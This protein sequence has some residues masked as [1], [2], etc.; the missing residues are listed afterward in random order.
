MNLENC[1]LTCQNFLQTL[2]GEFN[3]E[4]EAFIKGQSGKTTEPG[5]CPWVGH[6]NED[7]IKEEVLSLSAVSIGSILFIQLVLYFIPFYL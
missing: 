6:A 2:L 1:N 7:R 3:K 5:Q 4:Q